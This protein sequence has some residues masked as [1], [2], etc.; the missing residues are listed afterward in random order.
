MDHTPGRGER[1]RRRDLGPLG[2]QRQSASGIIESEREMMQD[3]RTEQTIHEQDIREGRHDAHRHILYG[4][5][6]QASYAQR[7]IPYWTV[8]S[9]AVRDDSGHRW[10]SSSAPPSHCRSCAQRCKGRGGQ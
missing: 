10:V 1:G 9:R 7:D 5:L 4:C 6:E 3:I 2:D 8:P